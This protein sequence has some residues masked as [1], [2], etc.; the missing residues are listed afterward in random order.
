[1]NQLSGSFQT[2][3]A[4]SE[5][6]ALVQ[7]LRRLQETLATCD[8]NR[9][10]ENDLQ[11]L[12]LVQKQGGSCCKMKLCTAGHFWPDFNLDVERCYYY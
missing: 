11:N 8:V 9:T 6:S 4:R 1:M 7:K 2:V 5:L 10:R 12:E 3:S